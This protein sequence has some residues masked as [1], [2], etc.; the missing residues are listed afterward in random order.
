MRRTDLR[1]AVVGAGIAGLAVAAALGRAGLSCEVFEQAPYLAEVGAG[2]QL[3][4]NAVRLLYRLGLADHLESVAVRPHALHMRRWDDGGTIVRTPLADCH[5]MFGAPYYAIHR[6]DLHCG[7]IELLPP[8]IVHLGLRCVAVTEVAGGAELTLSDGSVRTADVVIGADGIHSMV[9]AALVDDRPRYSGQLIYRGLVSAA[10]VPFLRADPEVRLWLGPAQHCVAYLVS[11]GTQ[12]SFAATVAAPDPGAES[13]SAQG[14]I[15]DVVPAYVG[16]HPDVLALL[17]SA[18]RVG[19]WALHDRDPIR[20]WSTER[21]TLAGDA[22]HPMLPFLA[23]GANQAIEDAVVLARCFAA[24]DARQPG[25][26]AEA[27]GRYQKLRVARTEEVHRRSRANNRTLHLG[28]GE[29][30]RHRDRSLAAADLTGYTWIYGYDAEL[31][32]AG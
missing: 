28:D 25:G 17:T 31:A 30:Q 3:A 15:E 7:L 13:W 32:A 27:L 19:V 9:R 5:R 12:V 16:W 29:E 14:R 22:A 23:Q 8:G 26:V 6:A 11:G 18:E 1:I 2:I 24:I 20:R 10:K 21:I 4:P